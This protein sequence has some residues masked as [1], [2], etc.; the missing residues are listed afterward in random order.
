MADGMADGAAFDSFFVV[1]ALKDAL[2]VD[3]WGDDVVGV[4]VAYFD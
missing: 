2:D 3:A 4:E 1:G